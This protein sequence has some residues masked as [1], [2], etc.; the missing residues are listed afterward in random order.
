MAK[1]GASSALMREMGYISEQ[2][3]CA[4]IGVT[5]AT[6]RNRQCSGNAPPA[7]KVGKR[8]LFKRLDVELW[9]ARRVNR[10][11][12][13]APRNSLAMVWPAKHCASAESARG[14]TRR[15]RLSPRP[16][17]CG[18]GYAHT[19]DFEQEAQLKQRKREARA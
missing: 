4:L 5:T 15:W 16:R 6:L 13:A 7:Y 9:I 8:K 1:S 2:E 17:D 19:R 3:V 18:H 11:G 14:T 10:R 12:R